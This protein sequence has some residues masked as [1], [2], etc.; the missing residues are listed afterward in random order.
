M[1]LTTILRALRVTI[2]FFTL[3][4]SGNNVYLPPSTFSDNVNTLLA[5]TFAIAYTVT[6]CSKLCLVGP[7]LR[8]A[9]MILPALLWYSTSMSRPDTQH[10]NLREPTV[11]MDT[12][13]SFPTSIMIVLECILALRWEARR[14]RVVEAAK[15]GTLYEEQQQQQSLRQDQELSTMVLIENRALIP[16]ILPPEEQDN[17]E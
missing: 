10:T 6:L 7:Y 17:V 3:A 2:I 13:L 5:P 16:T 15:A 12:F 1:T 8:A 14:K 9:L 4:I 11:R